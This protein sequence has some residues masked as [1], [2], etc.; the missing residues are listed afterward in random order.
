MAQSIQIRRGLKAN[1][2]KK[3]LVGEL[4]YCTDT[5]Q[6]YI[7]TANGNVD[8][9]SLSTTALAGLM[10][11]S[12][13]TKLDGI[14]PGATKYAHPTGDGNL[15][16]PAT[17]TTNNNKVLKAGATAGSL[18]W[19]TLTSA[20]VGAAPAGHVGATGAAH[21]AATS[22]V[23]GFMAA[24][25]KSKLDGIAAGA[26]KYT[27]PAGDGNLHIPATGTT[28]NNKVLTAGST[29]G[30]L[31]WKTIS[32]LSFT[33]SLAENGW[34]RLPN[35]LILQWGLSDSVVSHNNRYT[36]LLP[37]SFAT[38]IFVGVGCEAGVVPEDVWI[39][40]VPVE[41]TLTKAVF[42]VDGATGSSRSFGLSWFAI[43]R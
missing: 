11:A 1:V 10:S 30:S 40:Y 43:G 22:S 23:A 24:A 13:K 41:S 33:Q 16:V 5:R 21:G 25:D 20:D 18:S 9:T 35:G 26:T 39:Q 29:A 36:I 31:S 27:H 42:F 28:N 7:G 4:G 3:L 8:I 2:P 32:D 34:T 19:G 12:D 37:I 17:G 6:L 38:N 15:H 14:A